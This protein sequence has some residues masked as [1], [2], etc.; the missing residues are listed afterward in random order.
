MTDPLGSYS[1]NFGRFYSHP[2]SGVPRPTA[3]GAQVDDDPVRA[4]HPYSP[5]PSITNI[6]KM[7][8]KDFL[9]GY[10]ARLVAE[11]AIPN[12]KALQ[13]TAE[14]FGD[15]V[16]I[17]MLKAVPNAPNAAGAVGDEVHAAIE[18]HEKGR[19]IP[20]LT[21]ITAKR[22]FAQYLYF[23]A[24]RPMELIRSEFT[25]WS[26]T[27]GYAGTGDLMLNDQDGLWIVDAKSGNQVHP[28]VAM[29]NT[30]IQQADVILNPEGNEFPMPEVNVLGVL[31]VRPMSVKLHRLYRTDE[32]WKAFL[33]CKTLF[34]WKRFHYDHTIESEPFKTEKPKDEK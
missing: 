5:K 19:E 26:Y 28:E 29:Q 4:A 12:L 22:M 21:T 13:A 31:H 18:C 23:R 30:A 34:D 3:F 25:V 7:L 27:H 1:T 14:K 6:M 10:Y 11:Y 16:A 32:A 2:A 20:V 9:P 8:D 17:G 24:Q 15:D 33:A